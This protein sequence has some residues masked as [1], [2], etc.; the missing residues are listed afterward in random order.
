MAVLVVQIVDG[1]NVVKKIKK[2]KKIT[3]FRFKKYLYM[4]KRI[5]YKTVNYL[6]R[7]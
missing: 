1:Q 6:G 3:F 4:N 2:N 7:K 5:K